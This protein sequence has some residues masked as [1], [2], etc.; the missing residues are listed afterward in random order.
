VS[1]RGLACSAALV[2][3]LVP[4]GCGGSSDEDDVK[5]LA[6]QVAN[7]DEKVCDHATGDFLKAVGGTKAKCRQAARQDTSKRRP[8]VGAVKVDGDKGTA[9]ITDG[10]AKATLQF[11]KDGG[12]WQIASVR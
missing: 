10:K 1:A 7:S 9:E 6:T 2:A 8:K 3:A 12:D 11:T 4:A 5:S